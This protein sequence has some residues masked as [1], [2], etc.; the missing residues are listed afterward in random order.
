MTEKI[1]KI[2]KYTHI[3]GLDIF[4]E[5]NTIS[6]I[7]HLKCKLYRKFQRGFRGISRNQREKVRLGRYFEY[8]KHSR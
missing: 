1:W 4:M 2:E 6:T 5:V 7:V 3:Y 8:R